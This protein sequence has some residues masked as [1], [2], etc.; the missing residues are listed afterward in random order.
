MLCKKMTKKEFKIN[1]ILSAVNSISKIDK[2]KSK[3]LEKKD[4]TIIE[5]YLE[6]MP[7]R[8]IWGRLSRSAQELMWKSVAEPIFRKEESLKS[9]YNTCKT[10]SFRETRDPNKVTLIK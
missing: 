1:D 10:S 9:F 7:E 2:K 8:N 4:S 6:S 5:D 3:I